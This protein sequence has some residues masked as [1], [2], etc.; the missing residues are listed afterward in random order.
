MRAGQDTDCNPANAASV[1]G[2]WKGRSGI[3][4]R[5]RRGLAYGR[6]FPFTDYTLRDAI[7]VNLRLARE[8]TTFRGGS[9]GAQWQVR[10]SPV[11]AP[12][13]EQWPL[14]PDRGPELAAT[15]TPVG[16][17]SV[18]F[19]ALASDPDGVRDVWW[20][21]GDLSGARGASVSHAYRTPGTYRVIVWASDGL[22]RTTTRQLS[23]QS[24]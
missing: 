19:E 1:I 17:G 8:L 13:F 6:S 11:E 7:R 24:G 15:A 21:F 3:P 12:A 23:V 10:P 22:G 20:S 9:A 18:S 4:K 14:V 5:F 2:T 16:G